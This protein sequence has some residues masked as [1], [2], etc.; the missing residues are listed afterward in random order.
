MSISRRVRSG[1][2]LAG[3]LLL[4]AAVAT[5][6]IQGQPATP[7]RG[8]LDELSVSELQGRMTRGQATARTLTEAYLKRIDE[9]DGRGPSLRSIIERNPDALA[10]A[11]QLDAERRA[12]RVRG[13]LHGI[14]IVIKDNIATGDRMRTT[15]GSLAL[16][17]SPAPRDAFVVAR[18]LRAGWNDV[19]VVFAGAADRLPAD[20]A[21]W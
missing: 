17:A 6:L 4:G 13:P 15:A 18:L 2:V 10:I 20:A 12:G 5:T 16:A 8:E 14:P 21:R 19:R 9:I 1:P 7:A 11:D 3:A